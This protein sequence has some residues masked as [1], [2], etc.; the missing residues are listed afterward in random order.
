[1]F[2]SDNGP[3]STAAKDSP[4]KLDPDANVTGYGTYYSVGETDGMKGRKRSFFEGG[5]PVPFLIR[6]L[7]HLPA[8]VKNDITAFPAVD[9]LPSFVFRRRITRAFPAWHGR[10]RRRG[11]G[12]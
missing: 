6:W 3:E 7:G 9:L 5:V 1:M 2:S 12:R 8:G 11:C 10:R 4:Q